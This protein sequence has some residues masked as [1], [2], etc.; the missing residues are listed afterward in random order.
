[1][2]PLKANVTPGNLLLTPRQAC[3]L[4]S[5]ACLLIDKAEENPKYLISKLPDCTRNFYKKKQWRNQLIES[6]KR[7]ALRMAKRM[8]I[9]TNCFGE[10]LF[11]HIIVWSAFELGWNRSR[12]QREQLQECEK[13]RDLSHITSGCVNEDVAA[14]YRLEDGDVAKEINFKGWFHANDTSAQVMHNHEIEGF[15]GK[16]DKEQHDETED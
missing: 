15:V 7:V 16:P 11:V 13:D 2:Y 1:M 14:L 9:S 5:D 12:E 4:F 3:K 8:G 6:G 10:D